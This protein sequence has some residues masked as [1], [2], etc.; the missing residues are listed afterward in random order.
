MSGWTT[1]KLGEVCEGSIRRLKDID[2]ERFLYIDI[3]SIDRERKAIV[4]AT[5]YERI[6]AP[7]RAQQV[8]EVGDVLVSTVRP[9]LNAVAIVE[10]KSNIRR[11]ASTGFCVL[12]ASE[13][14]LPRYIYYFTQVGEFIAPLV[15]V[16]EKAAYPSVTDKVVRGVSIPIP[17]LAE[18]KRIVAKI[19][20]AFEKIDKLKANAEKNLANAKELFQ[21][22]LD[23][24]MRPKKGW[25]EKRLGEIGEYRKGPFGSALTKRIFVP[26][27][28]NTIK[29]YE[30]KNAI[31]KS[32]TIGEY[33]ITREY[34]NNRMT[35]FEVLPGD[36][37]VSCA[38]TIGETFIMPENMERGIIN[39]ALMRM[40]ISS[41]VDKGYFLYYFDHVLKKSAN[42]LSNGSAM[43]NIPPFSVFK[44]L[45]IPLPPI[46]EQK[47]IVLKLD[48]LSQ[49][50]ETLQQNYAR[51]I[52]DCAE[53]R[54]AILREAF[55]GRL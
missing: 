41:L 54:Q 39:Q 32:A 2:D 26:K 28:E 45:L 35:G 13:C 49:K 10:G 12:R 30:Q 48:D 43:K 53:M 8:V 36:V 50:L 21:S 31:R 6:K 44:Q 42:A 16:S 51:Q 20:A 40:R 18:Q 5:E 22:A 47:R 52:A 23:E 38:G 46:E 25:V 17:P 55:E 11:I 3:S 27:G 33:Y 19:D 24:A 37:I 15:A 7:G 1:K 29:V 14:I 34:F 4:G 9:N